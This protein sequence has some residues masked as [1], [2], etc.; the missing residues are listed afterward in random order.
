MPPP[1]RC[2]RCDATL[3]QHAAE[4]PSNHDRR[5]E[6]LRG[7]RCAICETY[8]RTLVLNSTDYVLLVMCTTCWV[9]VIVVQDTQ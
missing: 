5:A 8:G 9:E 2:S 6:M 1:A 7:D 4:V 3:A